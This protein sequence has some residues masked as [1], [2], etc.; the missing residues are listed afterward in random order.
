LAETVST[1]QTWPL[2]SRG[3]VRSERIS[4]HCAG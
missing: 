2:V 4:D 3:T 1:Q